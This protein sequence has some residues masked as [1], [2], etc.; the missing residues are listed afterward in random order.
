MFV[1]LFQSITASFKCINIFS[2]TG[3]GVHIKVAQQ[4]QH[5]FSHTLNSVPISC[6]LKYTRAEHQ[7]SQM[8]IIAIQLSKNEHMGSW[9]ELTHVACWR[10][11]GVDGGDLHRKGVLRRG[12]YGQLRGSEGSFLGSKLSLVFLLVVGLHHVSPN[13]SQPLLSLASHRLRHRLC[14]RF[15]W[16]FRVLQNEAE[17]QMRRR[18]GLIFGIYSLG[19]WVKWVSDTEVRA[20]WFG[21]GPVANISS[22]A[23]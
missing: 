12:L 1:Q 19:E 10:R 23:G 4:N 9:R 8:C 6:S 2:K 13:S 18:K 22:W 21:F 16:G 14:R 11:G 17:D 3:I 5:K 20:C 7:Q 15:L